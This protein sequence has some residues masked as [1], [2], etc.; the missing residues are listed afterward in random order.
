MQIDV[1]PFCGIARLYC[2]KYGITVDGFHKVALKLTF[3]MENTFIN[4]K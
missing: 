3:D 1:W 2:R 4:I